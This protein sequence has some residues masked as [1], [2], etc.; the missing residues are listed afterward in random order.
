MAHYAAHRPL[1]RP[2]DACWPV[3]DMAPR[4]AIRDARRCHPGAAQ[5]RCPMNDPQLAAR[6]ITLWLIALALTAAFCALSV[7]WFDR[8]IA[9][10]VHCELAQP[11]RLRQP[12]AISE[13][14]AGAGVW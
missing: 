3:T 9:F 12:P 14:L 6:R 10:F 7:A 8:P 4:T 5:P 13:S 1:M 11:L 2:T